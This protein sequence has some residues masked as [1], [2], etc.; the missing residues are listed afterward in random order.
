MAT[1][2]KK[3][4]EKETPSEEEVETP[5]SSKSSCLLVGCIVVAIVFV[6][7]AVV[8]A[9]IIFYVLKNDDI[10]QKYISSYVSPKEEKVEPKQTPIVV[11]VTV[12]PTGIPEEN[13]RRVTTQGNF[14]IP[15]SS[16]RQVIARDL[17]GLSN[18]EL[19]VARNEIYARHGRPFVH[20]DLQCYFNTQS[21]YT[22]DPSYTDSRLSK[23][24]LANAVYILNYEKSIGSTIYDKD[25]GCK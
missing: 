6:V 13:T 3:S 7:G 20:T 8:V 15:E 24:E 14:I 19:K 17:S 23:L 11:V 10:I 4:I 2:S 18:W 25:T 9:F 12:I 22:K 16:I 1:T 5:K 21:W